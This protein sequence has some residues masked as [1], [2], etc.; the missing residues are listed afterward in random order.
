MKTKLY[1]EVL[2]DK[3]R[4]KE[5]GC[6]PL[7][8]RISIGKQRWYF[9]VGF[10]CTEEL[11]SRA[12]EPKPRK[13]AKELRAQIEAIKR[14]AEGVCSILPK[15]SPEVFRNEFFKNSITSTT[16]K[17]T[18]VFSVFQNY[19]Q[20][21]RSEGR[22]STAKSYES[23]MLSL[24]A[25]CDGRLSTHRESRTSGVKKPTP[26]FKKINFEDI[27]VQWLKRYALGLESVGTSNATIGI[28]CRSLRAVYNNA[29]KEDN[30][31][32]SVYP[33]G[34]GKFEIPM[35]S[36][37]KRALPPE[38]IKS[39]I[40]YTPES[41]SE[42]KAKDLW[43]F[44]YLCGGMNIADVIRLKYKQLQFDNDGCTIEFIREKT[45][46]KSDRTK[47]S[48]E[49]DTDTTKII[50]SIIKQHGNRSRDG[51]VFP[52]LN[53]KNTPQDQFTAKASLIRSV[54]KS[55]SK[56]AKNLDISIALTSYVARH[57]Y[58][59]VLLRAGVSVAA[60]SQSL[61][62]ADI[63]TTETYLNGFSKESNRKNSSNLLKF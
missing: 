35:A 1:F 62:H 14:E 33:F 39:I 41:E 9:P 50:T 34:K 3:R 37:N 25:Y 2:P 60:I 32:S 59:T 6:Y 26:K 24:S 22:I 27:T 5:N 43:I 57:S 30:T 7:R 23:A 17:P 10:E 61:G 55:L 29:M 8:L 56:I 42:Q 47:L 16:D 58:A 28:Y 48:I 49:L 31:L 12:Y 53:D 19:I 21:L 44:S 18:D 38:A 40:S 46:R 51:Y 36:K 13:D 11:Y 20:A 4:I 45:K 63:K 54:N 15:F 52:F